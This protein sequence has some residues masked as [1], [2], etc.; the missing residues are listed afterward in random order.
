M[1][2]EESQVLDISREFTNPHN[3][4]Q[5][6]LNNER[7]VCENCRERTSGSGLMLPST[8]CIK[9]ETR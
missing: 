3:W 2:I 7:F 1:N 6:P 5:D 4:K 9:K 8:T